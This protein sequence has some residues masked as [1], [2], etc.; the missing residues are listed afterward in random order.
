[1]RKPAFRQGA[2]SAQRLLDP[3]DRIGH[4]CLQRIRVRL[5]Y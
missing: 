2:V 4:E 1:M 5:P 3:T